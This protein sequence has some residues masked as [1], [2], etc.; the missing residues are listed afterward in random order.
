MTAHEIQLARAAKAAAA[1]PRAAAHPMG[2]LD[3]PRLARR[4]VIFTPAG[5]EISAL[6]DRARKD[7]SG[8]TSNAII[9]RV[10][11]HNP[12]AFWAIAR[13][14]RFNLDAPKGEGFLAVL[15]LNDE[16]MKKLL[17]GTLDTRNPDLS[18]ITR[19]S[20]QPAG[21]YVWCIHAR[22]VNAA[23]IPLVFQKFSTPLYRD[24]DLYARAVTEDGFRILETLGFERGAQYD[25]LV[26]PNLHM[27]TRKSEPSVRNLPANRRKIRVDVARSMED[28]VRAI[29]IRGAVYM[30][31]QRC[32]YNEE[33][34]GND[35]S[36]SHLIGYLG[37][38]PAG[39][40]RIR[41]FA[42][43]AKIERLAVRDEARRAGVASKIVQTAIDLCR[44]KGYQKIYAHSQKRLLAF[45]K[46]R[47]FCVVEGSKD[48]V[49]SDYNYIEVRLET[50][51]H[52]HSI[53]VDTDPY[54]VI[55]P[56]GSWHTPGV[57]EY[58]KTRGERRRPD[59][60]SA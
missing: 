59:G 56:E 4:M 12:D 10:V 22:G 54:V 19:Q 7:I 53:T 32:P 51:R 3:L 58:S 13:A 29:A 50:E 27:Y 45:W 36:A 57:L 15:T 9:H 38:E 41:Y 39:C 40:V 31:E 37:S 28:V 8:L 34:D 42:D 35:F 24:V 52:P 1:P 2:D 14:D 60:L 6:M 46:A 49:F 18:L 47:G 17:D 30:G 5:A 33:F 23:A 16:G 26:A 44:M 55:R 21:I 11:S 48:F 20:E 43:F 25:G